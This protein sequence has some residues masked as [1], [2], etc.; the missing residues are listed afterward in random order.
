MTRRLK[1]AA[2][3]YPLDFLDSATEYREKIRRWVAEAAGEE[4]Q[5]LVFPEYGAMELASLSGKD[6]AADLHMSMD[7]VSEQ[8]E[9]LMQVHADLAREYGVFIVSGSGPMRHEDS[10]LTNVARIFSPGG[11]HHEYHKLMPTPWEREAIGIDAGAASGLR[12][13]D[14]GL[15]RVGLVICYDI[16]FPLI[17]RALAEAGAEI[18]LAPSNTEK[19]HGYWRVRTGCMA[20]ALENQI[21]TVQSPTVGPAEWCEAV[22]ANV[23][24]AGIFVPSDADFPA[25]GV[26]A[27]GKINVPGWVYADIDLQ[28]LAD[29]RKNG[30]VQTYAHWSEQPGAGPLPMVEVLAFD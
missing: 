2:A 19:E 22:D 18:I 12:V 25:G 5:L 29:L 14:I 24:A 23:G 21:C 6:A 3:Q 16:E 1:I 27:C 9:L 15:A 20:R 26:L 17:A 8:S 28:C 11:N 4:A 13:F 30:H 10:S 7:A